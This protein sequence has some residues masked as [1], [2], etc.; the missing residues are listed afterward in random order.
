MP[1]T[2]WDQVREKY[3][4][5]KVLITFAHLSECVCVCVSVWR[6]IGY[7]QVVG[8]RYCAGFIVTCHERLEGGI[9]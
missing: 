1:G 6:G 9:P 7:Q 4:P 5:S 3:A 2:F 8:I